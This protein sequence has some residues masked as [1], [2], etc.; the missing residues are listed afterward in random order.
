MDPENHESLRGKES[1]APQRRRRRQTLLRRT[2]WRWAGTIVVWTFLI[3]MGLS[4]V[5]SKA[6]EDVGYLAASLLLLFFVL[7]GIVFDIIGLAVATASEKPFHSM[8]SRR[9]TGARHALWLLR[10]AEEVSSFCNDVVGDVSGIITGATAA[11]LAVNV[12]FDLD[13]SFVV[14]QLVVAALAA[15]MSVGGK[16]LGKRFAMNH[17]TQIVHWLGRMMYAGSRLWKRKKK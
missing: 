10:R 2:D 16:A 14:T 17:N 6:L 5:S 3:S 13:I 4:F 8:S 9:V 12:A 7:I 11:V 15:A 1:F